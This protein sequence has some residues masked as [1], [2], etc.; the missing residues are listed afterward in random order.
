M[1]AEGVDC[2]LMSLS[3]KLRHATPVGTEWEV[4]HEELRRRPDVV[5]RLM[6]AAGEYQFKFVVRDEADLAEV[7]EWVRDTGAGR[8]RVLLM[9]EGTT[10]EAMNERG[11]WLGDVC[12]RTGYRF[13]PRLHIYLYGNRRG[14]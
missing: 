2:D 10:V 6:H 13:A 5:R 9:P 11:A 3:P 12:K 4:R 1:W 8:G 14:M 7:D